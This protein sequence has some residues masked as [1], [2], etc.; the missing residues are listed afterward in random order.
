MV[1]VRLGMYERGPRLLDLGPLLCP[2]A[3]EFPRR[4]LLGSSLIKHFGDPRLIKAAAIEHVIA[5]GVDC[6]R[7]DLLAARSYPSRGAGNSFIKRNAHRRDRGRGSRPGR[8]SDRPGPT[9]T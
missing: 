1:L 8:G 9:T 6:S 5:G 3:S 4:T 2:N 7:D